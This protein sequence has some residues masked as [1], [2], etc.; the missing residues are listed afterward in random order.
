MS[1]AAPLMAL[2]GGNPGAKAAPVNAMLQGQMAH[3][4]AVLRDP[5]AVM[6]GATM[7][8]HRSRAERRSVAHLAT[9]AGLRAELAVHLRLQ[10]EQADMADRRE[11]LIERL[12]DD[13]ALRAHAEREK[14]EVHAR[15][16]QGTQEERLRLARD[17]HD[18][19]GQHVMS[20]KL[21]LVRLKRHVSDDAGRHILS[22]LVEQVDVAARDLH[23][24]ASELRP[25]A[26][27]EFGLPV[28]LHTQ[29][30][31]WSEMT[32][33][34]VRFQSVGTAVHLRAEAEETLYRLAQE[35]LTNIAKHAVG[36]DVVTMLLQYGIGHVALTIEDDGC[37]FEQESG[38]LGL[39]SGRGRFGLIGMRERLALVGGEV[40]I[41]ST[42]GRGTTVFA[43]I[44]TAGSSDAP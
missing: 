39:I 24:L 31:D 36:A 5:V 13:A 29:L 2:R 41:E 19:A 14:D 10:R 42:S 35:A 9:V 23:R 17:L 38:G 8:E 21:G 27:E 3:L 22:G 7:I 32:G 1:V 28:A 34:A 37:G 26:L 4:P 30:D 33:V 6:T 12:Q 20:L 44:L 25:A 15:L 18:H 11:R 43:R 16:Y 40:E